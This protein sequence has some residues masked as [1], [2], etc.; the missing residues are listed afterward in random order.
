MS[1]VHVLQALA[2][3]EARGGSQQGAQKL[4]YPVPSLGFKEPIGFEEGWGLSSRSGRRGL[5]LAAC[6]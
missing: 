1:A 4:G 2:R 5:L 3:D 6:S